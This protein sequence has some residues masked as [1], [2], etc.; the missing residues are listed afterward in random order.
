MSLDKWENQG[1]KGDIQMYSRRE[2]G[3]VGMLMEKDID[4]P[5]ERFLTILAE[6]DYYD[7]LIPTITQ[8]KEVKYIDRNH[9][10]GYCIFDFPVLSQR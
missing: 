7:Q 8:S 2:G 9:K 10:L 1:L 3:T 5:V 6:M 4:I